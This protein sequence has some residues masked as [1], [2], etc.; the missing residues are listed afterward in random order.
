MTDL[1]PPERDEDILLL[2]ALDGDAEAL[3]IVETREHLAELLGQMRQN[4]IELRETTLS[5]EPESRTSS[6][7]AAMAVFDNMAAS[8][9]AAAAVRAVSQKRRRT[10][11]LFRFLGVAAAST[12]VVVTAVTIGPNLGSSGDGATTASRDEAAATTAAATTAA[13]AATATT[14]F[15][16]S[17]AGATISGEDA[18]LVENYSAEATFA[19]T[20]ITEAPAA[21]VA[22]TTPPTTEAGEA[23]DPSARQADS[24]ALLDIAIVE[25]ADQA[26]LD[27]AAWIVS[28]PDD[29]A[30]EQEQ[31]LRSYVVLTDA[32]FEID[33]VLDIATCEFSVSEPRVPAPPGQ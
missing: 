11:N 28:S 12:A 21:S 32:G 5:I 7:D 29:G 27:I 2:D 24:E 4:R 23:L 15:D 31:R 22:A 13:P 16:R 30:V 14:A 20:T 8:G 1:T 17:G 26:G 18:S 25:C 3:A 9:S 10:Q 6:I 33:V 19:P